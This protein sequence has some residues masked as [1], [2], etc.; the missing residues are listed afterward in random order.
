M[1]TSGQTLQFHCDLETDQH[2]ET[3]MNGQSLAEL[4]TTQ[5]LKNDAVILPEKLQQYIFSL[6]WSEQ[7]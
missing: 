5:T 7:N 6:H 4:I 1:Q 3:G 2:T